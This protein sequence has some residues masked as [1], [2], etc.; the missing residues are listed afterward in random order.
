VSLIRV[1]EIPVAEHM[2]RGF[3]FGGG[4][5]VAFLQVDWFRDDEHPLTA[6]TQADYA[7][8]IEP[9]GY[10]ASA[11]ARGAALL[12]LSPTHSFTIGYEAP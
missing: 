1:F 3:L 2:A 9:K 4:K 7:K 12:V 11:R 5:P 10:A 6:E 8:F